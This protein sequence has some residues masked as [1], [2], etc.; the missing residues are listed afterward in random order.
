MKDFLTAGSYCVTSR[1]K[2]GFLMNNFVPLSSLRLQRQLAPATAYID[3]HPGMLAKSIVEGKRKLDELT[4]NH[5]SGVSDACRLAPEASMTSEDQFLISP[6]EALP[7]PGTL[8]HR[9][10]QEVHL[11][12]G[13]EEG[14]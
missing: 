3:P 10:L 7:L 6:D 4:R 14:I 8:S 1:A 9:L 5:L 11:W 13:V 2:E 12:I